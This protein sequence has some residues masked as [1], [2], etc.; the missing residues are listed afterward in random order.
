M[1]AATLSTTSTNV[2]AT[3]QLTHDIYQ[4]ANMTKEDM[5]RINGDGELPKHSAWFS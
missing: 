5:C 3:K 2:D 4:D 1:W